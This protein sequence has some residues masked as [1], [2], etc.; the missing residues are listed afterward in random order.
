[1]GVGDSTFMWDIGG[2]K[3]KGKGKS[4][5]GTG[6]GKGPGGKGSAKGLAEAGW[7]YNSD[8]R[9]ACPY[10]ASCK[11]RHKDDKN[12]PQNKGLKRPNPGRGTQEESDGE[13]DAAAPRGPPRKQPRTA[14]PY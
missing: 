7:C 5:K 10:G 11:Y 1:M 9:T 12:E 3:G 6:K 14:A 2:G 4:G 13:S 8:T